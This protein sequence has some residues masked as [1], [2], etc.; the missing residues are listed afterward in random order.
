MTCQAC[1]TLRTCFWLFLLCS[2]ASSAQVRLCGEDGGPSLPSHT[3]T[4]I[5]PDGSMTISAPDEWLFLVENQ[6]QWPMSAT[7]VLTCSCSGGSGCSPVLLPNGQS[8][9]AMSSDCTQCSRGGAGAIYPIR[10]D[11]A[12]ITLASADE[13]AGL[14]RADARLLSVPAVR[15]DL[16]AFKKAMNIALNARGQST[17]WIRLYGY[18]APMELPDGYRVPT[19]SSDTANMALGLLAAHSVVVPTAAVK[20]SCTSNGSCTLESNF[21]VKVCNASNSSTC[22]MSY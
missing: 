12:G 4:H 7:A 13:V 16:L 9:Y 8:F 21:G 19:L 5:N 1:H 11:Q 18:V 2:A 20:C 6:G 15:E 17:I 10:E 14:P 3:T 22:S